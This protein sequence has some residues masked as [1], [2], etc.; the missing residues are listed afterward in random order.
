MEVPD[1]PFKL[2][3]HRALSTNWLALI[4]NYA[5][6]RRTQDFLPEFDATG[7]IDSSAKYPRPEF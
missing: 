1:H 2:Y 7:G 4:S 3:H 5:R 6:H